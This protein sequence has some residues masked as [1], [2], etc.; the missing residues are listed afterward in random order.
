[1]PDWT[2]DQLDYIRDNAHLGAE[3]IAQALDKS[4]GSVRMQASRQA[5]SLRAVRQPVTCTL[6]G[7][8]TYLPVTQKGHCRRCIAKQS[9][10]RQEERR[11]LWERRINE[12]IGREESEVAQY[13]RDT[14][15]H[16]QYVSRAKRTLSA[17]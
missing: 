15:R 13:R 10:Q 5:I 7:R 8:D 4:V 1:M 16:K 14:D 6:C 3:A 9:A 12:A 11:K 17:K 2:T